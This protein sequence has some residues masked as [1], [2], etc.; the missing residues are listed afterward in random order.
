M[1]YRTL[2]QSNASAREAAKA[3]RASEIWWS[4]R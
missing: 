3:F 1:S 4:G 2:A